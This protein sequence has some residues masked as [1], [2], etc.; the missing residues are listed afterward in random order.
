M[1]YENNIHYLSTPKTITTILKPTF[2]ETISHLANEINTYV[3]EK[4]W[5][6]T[7]SITS[8]TFQIV[9]YIL[10]KPSRSQDEILIIKII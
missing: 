8:T 9:T 6:I 5:N 2:D 10:N 4:H 1:S 7:L 3:N